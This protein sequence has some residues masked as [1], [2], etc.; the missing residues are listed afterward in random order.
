MK[1][2]TGGGGGRGG[3]LESLVVVFHRLRCFLYDGLVCAGWGWDNKAM[4]CS[5]R[6]IAVL[7]PLLLP[8]AGVK[9]M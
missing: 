5:V 9:G 6:F 2:S 1:E 8:C 7:L 4:C 3:G